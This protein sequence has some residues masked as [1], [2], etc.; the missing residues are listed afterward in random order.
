MLVF[1]TIIPEA[2]LKLLTILNNIIKGH[3]LFT[4]YQKYGMAQ[5]LII[6]ESLLIF[7]KNTKE[8]GS[9]I[10]AKYKLVIQDVFIQFFTP[11]VLQR[12][13]RYLCRGLYNP[14]DTKIS[15]FICRVEK[16]FEHLDK[17]PPFGVNQGFQKRKYSRLQ[18]SL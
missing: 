2:L 15:K 16:I 13:N 3:D 18:R 17:F 1:K 9:L 8:R 7:E 10:N 5:N 11:K 6:G 4:G 12:Q 14:H